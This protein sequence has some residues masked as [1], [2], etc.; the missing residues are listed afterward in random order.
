MS[1][2]I[3]V[4]FIVLFIFLM[5]G[6]FSM[7]EGRGRSKTPQPRRR[8]RRQTYPPSH[9]E[10]R[11]TLVARQAMRRAGYDMTGEYVRVTDIGLLEHRGSDRPRLLRFEKARTDSDPPLHRH[12]VL[13]WFKRAL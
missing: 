11:S 4:V 7:A 2:I 1:A 13:L 8:I 3:F 12:G 9:D 10:E 6:L 5:F